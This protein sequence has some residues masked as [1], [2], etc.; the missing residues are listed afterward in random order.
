MTG[1]KLFPLRYHHLPSPAPG[2]AFLPPPPL[3]KLEQAAVIHVGS[4][5]LFS[6]SGV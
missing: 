3:Q 5:T 1:K 6:S 2:C 4:F